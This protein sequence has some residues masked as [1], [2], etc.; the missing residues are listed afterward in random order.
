MTRH[1]S[2]APVVAAVALCAAL[3]AACKTET[4]IVKWDP[5][6]GGLPGAESQMPVL[7][8]V[9]DYKDPT[10]VPDNR[11]R[12]ENE[13]GTVTLIAKSGRHLMVHIYA[14][15]QAEERELFVEQVLSKV[16]R[17]EYVQRGLDPAKAF[18]DLKLRR[19]DMA[20]LFSV[21][22]AGEFTPGV[23][24]QKLGNR[25]ARLQVSGMAARGLEWTC[26]DMVMEDGNWRLRWFGRPERK[27]PS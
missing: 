8:D 3:C 5:F 27:R 12:I 15:L 21:M 7:R 18:D 11:I 10:A 22:P 16:T 20:A 4:R 17:N 24:Y 1:A 9:G 23:M 14:T 25:M 13:D 2:R 6:L 26:M 19:D